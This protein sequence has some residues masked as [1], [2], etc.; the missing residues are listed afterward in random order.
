MKRKG[1]VCVRNRRWKALLIIASII[2]LGLMGVEHI[3]YRRNLE[4]IRINMV[5]NE[6]A[7]P[8]DSTDFSLLTAT[9][10]LSRDT[11]CVFSFEVSE[12]SQATLMN[13]MWQQG[14][15]D[16]EPYAKNIIADIQSPLAWSDSYSGLIEEEKTAII[17]LIDLLETKQCLYQLRIRSFSDSEHNYSLVV[18]D[19]ASHKLYYVQYS[20]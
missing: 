10:I 3:N 4:A 11:Y 7:L 18:I 2:V 14:F 5:K 6:F 15:I 8:M 13:T 19:P 9:S 12:A 20:S 16:N 1:R 17:A